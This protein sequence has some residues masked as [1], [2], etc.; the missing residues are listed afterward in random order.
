MNRGCRDGDGFFRQLVG[1]PG[2]SELA[3]RPELGD[4][5]DDCGAG[6]AWV[7]MRLAGAVQQTVLTVIEPPAVPLAQAL[8]ADPGLAG[9]VRDRATSI[10]SLTQATATFRGE[11]SVS[12]RHEDLSGWQWMLG[13][14]HTSPGGPR[15]VTNKR[16]RVPASPTSPGRTARRVYDERVWRQRD[17]AKTQT[18][19]QVTGAQ[20][21][22]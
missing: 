11:R 9:D 10:N 7:A 18:F 2:G 8:P 1:D 19:T 5:G 4:P 21:R 22:P 17:Q 20:R 14:T 6:P 15:Y 12:V 13:G 3:G 16:G